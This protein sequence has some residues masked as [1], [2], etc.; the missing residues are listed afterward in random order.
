MSRIPRCCMARLSSS[1]NLS[2]GP[3]MEL[4]MTSSFSFWAWLGH[5]HVQIE[6][7]AEISQMSCLVSFRLMMA[8]VMSRLCVFSWPHNSLKWP[9]FF[10]H[11]QLR[12]QWSPHVTPV[13]FRGNWKKSFWLLIICETVRMGS[14]V[15]RSLLRLKPIVF[16]GSVLRLTNLDS[17]K[18]RTK[19]ERY[20]ATLYF[21]R[22]F[23]TLL[24]AHFILL[25]CMYTLA[26]HCCFVR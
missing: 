7:D 9:K 6:S 21:F 15:S 1:L 10:Q 12:S 4:A 18:T 3:G 26:V 22:L 20:R 16:R 13:L 11:V 23:S 2:I 19:K 14:R 8:T 25:S 5:R 24:H 17:T